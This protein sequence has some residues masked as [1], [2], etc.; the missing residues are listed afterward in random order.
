MPE[1]EISETEDAR[2]I[3]FFE[4]AW[5]HMRAADRRCRRD[6]ET[7]KDAGAFNESQLCY[8]WAATYFQG[9]EEDEDHQ[10]SPL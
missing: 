5:W 10:S 9:S 6:D 8:Q 7:G 2:R 1:E 4:I 3:E